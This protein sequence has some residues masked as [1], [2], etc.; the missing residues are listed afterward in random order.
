MI[1]ILGY[2]ATAV[3]PL[4]PAQ[5]ADWLRQ[6]GACLWLKA[7]APKATEWQQ[8]ANPFNFRR[9]NVADVSRPE[10]PLYLDVYSRYIFLGWP[11][12][13]LADGRLAVTPLYI[14]LGNN[15]VVTVQADAVTAVDQT[16]RHYQAEARPWQYGPDQLVQSIV[17]QLSDELLA[18]WSQQTALPALSLP[19]AANQLEA[20]YRQQQEAVRLRQ[21]LTVQQNILAPLGETEHDLVDANVRHALRR[22]R[23]QATSLAGQVETESRRLAHQLDAAQLDLTR[24][25]H[26][27][28]NQFYLTTTILLA[29]LLTLGLGILIAL[30]FF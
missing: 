14:F 1:E 20:L 3:Q 10:Q 5:I 7:T 18:L 22:Q 23:Q 11:A 30:L 9:H 19:P 12:L 25:S 17:R 16:W 27:T 21:Q 26:E 15:F 2:D 24:R 29:A 4:T 28:L 8:A 6:T 13:K